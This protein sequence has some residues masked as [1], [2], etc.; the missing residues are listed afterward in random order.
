MY[1]KLSIILPDIRTSFRSGNYNY[2]TP[3]TKSANVNLI[4]EI[5]RKYGNI[6][7]YWGKLFDI[8]NGVIVGFIATE[9]GG[10]MTKPNQYLATGLMQVTPAA[11]YDSARKWS[12]EVKSAPLPTPAVNLLKQKIPNF[13]DS[14]TSLA[15]IQSKILLYLQSDANFNV[16]AGTIVLRWL[17]ERFSVSGGAGQL[18]KAMVG[19]NAGAYRDI[20]SSGGTKNPVDSTS[21]A[22]NRRVPV[23]SR[24]YLMK[25]LGKDGF[26]ELIY[27]QKLAVV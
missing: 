17:I 26:L 16:M 21:L 25:M 24:G 3:S 6:T 11:I 4:K 18:N 27:L 2:S 7:S 10:V 9:S 14:R 1:T 12:A 20:L 8:P 13:F 5:N 23:E 15:S 19:Y 22:T